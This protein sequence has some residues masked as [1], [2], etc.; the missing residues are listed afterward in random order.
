MS[1]PWEVDKHP[2]RFP[3]KQ[4]KGSKEWH[5]RLQV[6]FRSS[7][8]HTYLNYGHPEWYSAYLKTDH[9]K[10]FKQRWRASQK[11]RCMICSN[12][13]YELHHITYERIG[14]ELLEDV[15]PLCRAHH[16][17]A[18]RREREG[19]PLNEAHLVEQK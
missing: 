19:V 17:R 16:A 4:G 6:A 1:F 18:H 15:V 14:Q 12:P 9:W 10:D 2:D 8:R 7:R 5:D 3:R 13:H 11:R